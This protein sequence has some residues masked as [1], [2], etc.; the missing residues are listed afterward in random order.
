MGIL[1]GATSS[2]SPLVA[3]L[4]RMILLPGALESKAATITFELCAES[5]EACLLARAGGAD[6]I[7]LCTDLDAD[8][9]TPEDDLVRAAV[10][11]SG[12]P[13]FMLVRPR[14]RDF[15]YSD[16]EFAQM[17]QDVLRGRDLGVSGFALGVLK[18]DRS[19]D[20]ARTQALVKLA[21]PLEVTFHRAFDQTPSLPAAF[22]DVLQTGCRRILTSGGALDVYRGAA[23][24]TALVQ[25]AR[26]RIEIAAGGGLRAEG[27]TDLVRQT[28][29]RHFHGSVRSY[30]EDGSI[31]GRSIEDRSGRLPVVRQADVRALTDQLRSGL[32][33][34]LHDDSARGHHV[35]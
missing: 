15:V 19:V 27:A 28:G 7:E 4:E 35:L 26:G 11:R 17:Q 14:A 6:R 33:Q 21:G 1:A 30:S 18:P 12:L 32:A 8:G 24:L 3:P 16:P 34:L 25:Q 23:A 13:V 31:E 9:L 2:G 10:E 22:E 5:L 20:V 29:G